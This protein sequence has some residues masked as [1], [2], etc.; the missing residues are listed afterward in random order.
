MCVTVPD[1]EPRRG[2]ERDIPIYILNVIWYDVLSWSYA[3]IN[4][5]LLCVLMLIAVGRRNSTR[6]LFATEP[7]M[8]GKVRRTRRLSISINWHR[9]D[10]SNPIQLFALTRADA[11]SS[12]KSFPSKLLTFAR[13]RGRKTVRVSFS[14]VSVSRRVMNDDTISSVRYSR[15]YYAFRAVFDG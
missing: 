9:N 8:T 15:R 5:I 6:S 2:V 4:Y 13:R 11:C 7:A 10:S 1:G 14:L 12:Q 3:H